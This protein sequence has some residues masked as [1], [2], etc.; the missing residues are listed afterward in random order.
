MLLVLVAGLLGGI[1]LTTVGGAV[2]LSAISHPVPAEL[3]TTGAVAI[4]GLAAL[5]AGH[6]ISTSTPAP[7]TNVV[8]QPP[9]G[10]APASPVPAAAVTPA[11][12]LHDPEGPFEL[13]APPNTGLTPPAGLKPSDVVG[14]H[15]DLK[16]PPP[17]DRS[18]GRASPPSSS[19]PPHPSV[20]PAK[21]TRKSARA[22]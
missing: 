5:L 13:A 3:W 2:T 18:R 9:D 6:G 22:R 14:G 7:V 10:V 21:E 16:R 4:G 8:N 17:A 19:L 15:P 11:Q 12:G 20:R 1:G